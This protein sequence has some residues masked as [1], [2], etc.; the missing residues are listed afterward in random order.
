MSFGNY[1]ASWAKNILW[2][3]IIFF[4]FTFAISKESGSADIN[5]YIQEYAA[6]FGRPMTMDDAIAYYDQ[7]GELD[8]AR[9]VIAVTL[10]RFSNSPVLIT[11]VY[12]LI[13][14]F[15]YS[16]NVVYLLQQLQ[17]PLSKWSW[18]LFIAFALVVPFWL[19]NGFRFWTATHIF[20]Y[21]VLPYLYEGKHKKLIFVPLAV[22]F[23]FSYLIPL[24][25]VATFFLVPKRLGFLILVFLGTVVYNEIN[26]QWLANYVEQTE[27][28]KI[29]ERA[30]PYIAQERVE[31]FRKGELSSGQVNWYVTWYKK[32][33]NYMI[34]ASFLLIYGLQR[35]KRLLT[36]PLHTTFAFALWFYS[37]A[38]ILST[39]PS[40]GRFLS[41][42]QL[43]ALFL[44][45]ILYQNHYRKLFTRY[46]FPVSLP[47]LLLFIVVAIREG[48][49]YMSVATVFGN[50]VT[51]IIGLGEHL[52]L[53][54]LIK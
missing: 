47:V 34:L 49:Y 16:R 54:D 44:I 43:L 22:L 32:G 3:F 15:F 46:V 19:I 20:I 10:S 13:F 31:A 35:T 26:V 6:L 37:F 42:A 50:P 17:G 30:N 52:A 41:V 28:E 12:A 25:S 23:H 18:L 29:I 45:L 36:K 48:F 38:N 40:G 24:I 51:A 27:E 1:R 21:G 5:R 4:G 39:I 11:T 9:T 8:M 2:A 53:N 7:R 14:G 33:I